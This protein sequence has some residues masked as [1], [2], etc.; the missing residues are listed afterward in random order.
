MENNTTQTR[1]PTYVARHV[2]VSINRPVADVYNF[3]SNPQHL[4][5]WAS[6]LSTGAVKKEGDLWLMESPMGKVKVKFAGRNEF[7]IID[8]EVTLPSGQKV[9]N[10]VRVLQNNEGCEIIFTVY[11]LP[12]V[13][14]EAFEKD[15]A[16][17]LADLQQLKKILER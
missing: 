15:A 3:A 4:P 16:T 17:V 7:G 2:S 10:P 9:Y 14:N 1:Q 6:G 8:H 13:T 12:D 5:E 11:R